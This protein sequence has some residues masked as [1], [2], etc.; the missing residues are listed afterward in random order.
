MSTM[1]GEPL[2]RACGY[3]PLER[4][5]DG[6]GGV[7]VPLVR[8]AKNITLIRA[9]CV[10]FGPTRFPARRARRHRAVLTS[11]PFRAGARGPLET[12]YRSPG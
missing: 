12:P 8:M 11:S 6:R 7:A 9:C 1:A 3:E 4:V 2:Y 10:S 5:E